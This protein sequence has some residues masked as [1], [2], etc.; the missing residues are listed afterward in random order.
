MEKIHYW[1]ISPEDWRNNHERWEKQWSICIKEK[2]IA[3]GWS[4]VGD[5]SELNIDEI[6]DRLQTHYPKYKKSNYK[7]RLTRDA[8]Q[9]LDFR[10]IENGAIIVANKGQKEIVG[11]GRVE[12]KYY[13]N[14]IP[15]DFKHT[16]PVKR[17]DTE[18]REIKQQESWLQTV[19]PLTELKV[20]ELGIC[21]VLSTYV[22]PDYFI[23]FRFLNF[24][25]MLL[26]YFKKWFRFRYI[27]INPMDIRIE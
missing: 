16:L 12:N 11:I 3:M 10:N 9:L 26:S 21:E 4:N 20:Q 5:L 24:F 27:V 19:M 8:Q 14:T 25:Q 6:K 15:V 1:K 22:Y 23:I 2:K 7:T 13:F 18:I 17:L